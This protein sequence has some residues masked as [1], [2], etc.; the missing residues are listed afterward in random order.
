MFVA[1]AAVS[2][3]ASAQQPAVP[4]VPRVQLAVDRPADAAD[5]PDAAA[6][7]SAVS[8]LV[9]RV[10][11]TAAPR[12][13]TPDPPPGQTLIRVRVLRS[14]AGY[15]ASIQARGVLKGTRALRDESSSS[16]GGLAEALALT[17]SLMLDTLD[18]PPSPRPAPGIAQPA[19]VETWRLVLELDGAAVTGLPHGLRPALVGGVD[20]ARD[21]VALGLGVLLPASQSASL[22]PGH[23]DVSLQILLARACYAA[24]RSPVA[25][26]RVCALPSA[27]ILRAS[28]SGYTTE[29]SAARPWFAFGGELAAHGFLAGPWSWTLR[30][31]MMLAL[32]KES[33]A[34]DGLG[35]AHTSDRIGGFLA[36][37]VRLTIW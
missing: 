26:L 25:Q 2:A 23:V 6:L 18:R 20:A 17:L 7:A 9:Q 5:C 36:V 34:I 30:S 11:L 13:D 1:V 33:F 19:R 3:V 12:S 37:G 8:S 10:V 35:L 4:A 29:G 21:D 16:C 14:E 27:G 24:V 28:S 32:R 22:P 15:S 31:G